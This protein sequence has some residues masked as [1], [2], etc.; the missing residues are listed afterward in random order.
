M[1]EVTL[2]RICTEQMFASQ[3]SARVAEAADY[4][5]RFAGTCGKIFKVAVGFMLSAPQ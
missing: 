4:D 2:H 5:A 1:P 3:A